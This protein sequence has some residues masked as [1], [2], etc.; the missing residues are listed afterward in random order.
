M[1]ILENKQQIFYSDVNEAMMIKSQNPNLSV[2]ISIENNPDEEDLFWNSFSVESIIK[3]GFI[4]V[5]MNQTENSEAN[6]DPSFLDMS[7]QLTDLMDENQALRKQLKDISTSSQTKDTQESLL[8]EINSLEKKKK[9]L[10]SELENIKSDILNEKEQLAQQHEEP[11]FDIFD[12]IRASLNETRA[13]DQDL[14]ERVSTLLSKVLVQ[15]EDY[16]EEMA[17]MKKLIGLRKNENQQ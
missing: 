14:C 1:E 12:P 8:A 4:V 5:R 7:Q 16:T 6:L 15:I 17:F 2:L 3:T 13:F 9:E 11:L 10:S